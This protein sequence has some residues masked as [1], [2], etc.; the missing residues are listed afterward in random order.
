MTTPTF[1]VVQMPSDFDPEGIAFDCGISEYNDWFGSRSADA[2]R[3][4]SA[5]VYLLVGDDSTRLAGF[6]TIS[7]TTVSSEGLPKRARGGL[8]RTAPGYLIGKLALSKDLQGRKPPLGPQLV[9]AAIAKVVDAAAVGGGQI[10][11]VDA[12]NKDLIP[13]YEGC[14]F[15]ST[16]VPSTLRLY[17]KVAT[18]RKALAT[19]NSK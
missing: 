4:G 14:G 10:I 17:M 11:V 16:G 2:V 13:F 7:P 6:F 1:R 15:L 18:A 19:G 9:L 8:M 5:S 3:S 12:D